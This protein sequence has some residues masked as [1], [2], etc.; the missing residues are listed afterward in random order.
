M[1]AVYQLIIES[2]SKATVTCF[3]FIYVK[4]SHMHVTIIL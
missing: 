1:T 3:I 4:S 2:P